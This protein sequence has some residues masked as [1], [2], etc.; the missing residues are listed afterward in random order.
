M[1]LK[2]IQNSSI[3]ILDLWE[4]RLSASGHTQSAMESIITSLV[5]LTANL[6]PRFFFYVYPHP[7]FLSVDS[8]TNLVRFEQ[9]PW[10]KNLIPWVF[11]NTF[12]IYALVGGSCI[13]QVKAQFFANKAEETLQINVPLMVTIIGLILLQILVDFLFLFY[14]ELREIFNQILIL[15]K[16]CKMALFLKELRVPFLYRIQLPILL[17]TQTKLRNLLFNSILILHRYSGIKTWN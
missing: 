11:I 17:Q 15:E 3:Y 8:E 9:R 16:K 4:V 6:Q 1:V 2:T 7:F 13:Y 12:I 10:N 14:P 5:T